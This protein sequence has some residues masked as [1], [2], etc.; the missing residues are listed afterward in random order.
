M[1]LKLFKLLRNLQSKQPVIQNFDIRL[2]A[3]IYF[4]GSLKNFVD[5]LKGDSYKDEV[6]EDFDLIFE[7]DFTLL[8][9]LILLTERLEKFQGLLILLIFLLI[10]D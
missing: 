7:R 8:Y 6:E 4:D 10:K 3:H 1:F 2:I 5:F 9:F